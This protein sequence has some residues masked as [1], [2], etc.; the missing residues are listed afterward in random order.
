MLDGDTEAA[1]AEAAALVADSH[2]THFYDPI[3]LAGRAFASAI[4]RHPE[5]Q[6][7]ISDSGQTDP[8][9]ARD[10]GGTPSQIAWD[11]YLFYDPAT[12]WDPAPTT[13]AAPHPTTWF[14]QLSGNSREWA[15]PDRY[16]WSEQLAEALAEEA[17]RRWQP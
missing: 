5:R 2:A 14:H 10:D 6:R 16:R 9:Q 1:A 17:A 4:H 7:G 3:Q 13:S 12:R 8:P 11:M 15:G